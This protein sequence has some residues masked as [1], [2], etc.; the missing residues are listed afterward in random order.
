MKILEV[1]N[2]HDSLPRALQMIERDGIRRESRNGPVLQHPTPVAT[3]YQEPRERVLFWPERDANPFFH[4]YESLWMLAGRNDVAGISKFSKQISEYSDDGIIFHAPYGHRWRQHFTVDTYGDYQDR[5]SIDQLE[6]ITNQLGENHDDRRCVLEIWDASVDLGRRG[7]DLPCNLTVTFQIGISGELDMVVFCRSNDLIW[8]TAG[9]NAVHF[10]ILQE[11]LASW[12]NM[13]IGTYTQISVNYH[14]YLK[15]LETVKDLPRPDKADF[16]SNP[17]PNLQVFPLISD[18]HH[19]SSKSIHVFDDDLQAMLNY[20]D[21]G[22]KIESFESSFPFLSL[23]YQLFSA[24][25]SWR[26]LD[27]PERFDVAIERVWALDAH[28]DWVVAC[29]QWLSRRRDAWRKKQNGETN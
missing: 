17:Y 18:E 12:I 6:I 21:N 5:S 2:V 8:G 20:V 26:T 7:K 23:A 13:P 15:T 11:Y 19:G 16:V 14:A 28:I 22:C 3:V 1:R 9:A 27:S 24:H 4:L 25:H 29:M 10:S